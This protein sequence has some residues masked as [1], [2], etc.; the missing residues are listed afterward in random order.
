MTEKNHMISIIHLLPGSIPGFCQ[1]LPSY[2]TYST[3][4]GVKRPHWLDHWLHILHYDIQPAL[5]TPETDIGQG[6]CIRHR[7]TRNVAKPPQATL[8]ELIRYVTDSKTTSDEYAVYAVRPHYAARPSQHL[9]FRD[10]FRWFSCV[11]RQCLAS[12]RCRIKEQVKKKIVSCI[13]DL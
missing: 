9:H 7:P 3:S 12:I 1:G 4:Q 6:T 10:D 5:L 13:S 11:P 8:L 2:S